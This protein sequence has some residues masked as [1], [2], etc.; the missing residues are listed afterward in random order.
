MNVKALKSVKRIEA[1]IFLLA[2]AS[3][4]AAQEGGGNFFRGMYSSS[5]VV[6]ENSRSGGYGDFGFSLLKKNYWDIRN[7]IGLHGY[8][9]SDYGYI[10]ISEKISLGGWFEKSEAAFRPYGSITVMASAFGGRG[11]SLFSVPLAMDVSGSGGFEIQYIKNQSFFIEYGGG[12]RFTVPFEDG[13]GVSFIS[14]G[15]RTYFK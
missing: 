6:L 11:K 2:A 9:S 13:E 14:A 15:I 4:L 8:G 7:S 12:Y 10:G 3:I 1:V 5:A